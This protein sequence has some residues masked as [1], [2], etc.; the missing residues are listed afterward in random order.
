MSAIQSCFSNSCIAA[1]N[2]RQSC[3]AK[4]YAMPLMWQTTERSQVTH[5][6]AQGGIRQEFV[7]NNVMQMHPTHCRR[8]RG[9]ITTS[10]RLSCL[11]HNCCSG[12]GETSQYET[13]SRL[14]YQLCHIGTAKQILQ[15]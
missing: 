7:S 1:L 14:C 2:A 15:I 6:L 4:C 13:V 12:T 3:M 11:T 10:W 9:H 5:M 8:W